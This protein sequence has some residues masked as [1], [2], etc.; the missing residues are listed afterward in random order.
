MDTPASRDPPLRMNAVSVPTSPREAMCVAAGTCRVS[1]MRYF[2]SRR[3]LFG[4]G[5]YGR[6]PGGSR[7]A[8]CSPL[9]A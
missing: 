1:Q 8:L 2:L 7:P 9:A 6:L 4:L 3:G 5:L